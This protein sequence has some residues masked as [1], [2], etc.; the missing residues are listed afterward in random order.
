MPPRNT[1]R[2]HHSSFPPHTFTPPRARTTEPSTPPTP[3]ASMHHPLESS[4][5]RPGHV[6]GLLRCPQKRSPAVIARSMHYNPISVPFTGSIR[7]GHGRK[8][9]SRLFL[10]TPS[11]APLAAPFLS[12]RH[13]PHPFPATC[14]YNR[15]I[16]AANVCVVPMRNPPEPSRSQPGRIAGPPCCSQS[17]ASITRRSHT[18][19]RR[20][21]KHDDFPDDDDDSASLPLYQVASASAVQNHLK[22]R[23][24][25]FHLPP[26]GACFPAPPAFP[27]P[28]SLRRRRSKRPL[29][30]H[31]PAPSSSTQL[32]RHTRPRSVRYNPFSVTSVTRPSHERK[33]RSSKHDN[34][35]DDDSDFCATPSRVLK[36]SEETLPTATTSTPAA[37]PSRFAQHQRPTS[38]RF[39]RSRKDSTCRPQKLLFKVSD[40]GRSEFEPPGRCKG[41]TRVGLGMGLEWTLYLN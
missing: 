40:R 9:R 36:A 39:E 30:T 38:Q 20:S 1:S 29:P 35:S 15:A 19:K 12:L 28:Q 21:S 4:R 23:V 14:L 6:A 27:H 8:R 2:H 25:L 17:V 5:S 33:R 32:Q 31:T 3:A 16:D 34:V 37:T 26:R 7:P 24:S 22:R 18:C 13:H 11:S 41:G 10:H